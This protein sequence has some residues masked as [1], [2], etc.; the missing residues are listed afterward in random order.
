[1]PLRP[2]WP[3]GLNITGLQCKIPSVCTS[4]Q[5]DDAVTTQDRLMDETSPGSRD[6][7]ST[8]YN[9]D[10]TDIGAFLQDST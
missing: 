8:A 1:M 10:A 6:D 3:R 7:E 9:T 2:F 5:T 4:V